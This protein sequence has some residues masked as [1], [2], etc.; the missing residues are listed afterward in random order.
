LV[1][2]GSRRYEV[3]I[4]R[5]GTFGS[6]RR[7]FTSADVQMPCTITDKL[8][9]LGCFLT[10]NHMPLCVRL[11]AYSLTHGRRGRGRRGHGRRGRSTCRPIADADAVSSRVRLSPGLTARRPPS[12][13]R[14]DRRPRRHAA[15]R[16]PEPAR[17]RHV[18]HRRRPRH[19]RLGRQGP[20]PLQPAE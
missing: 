13:R 7:F 15:R 5:A 1:A 4:T 19:R 14:R 12:R 17:G 20:R 6:E 16:L 8:K 9:R 10:F 11:S 2:G 3:G 18:Q